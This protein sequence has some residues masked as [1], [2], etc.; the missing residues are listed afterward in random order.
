MLRRGWY[1]GSEKF[2]EALLE[3]MKSPESSVHANQA[4]AITKYH[5]EREAERLLAIGLSQLGIHAE[6]LQK[7]PKGS[8][9]KIAVATVIKQRTSVTNAWLAQH[10]NMGSVTRVSWNCR[11]IF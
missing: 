1:F 7:L 2:R 4:R 5:D 3:K 11:H 8:A 6:D 10:L 9:G